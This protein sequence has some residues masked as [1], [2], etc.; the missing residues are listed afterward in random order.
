MRV[1]FVVRLV[2][3]HSF[4]VNTVGSSGVGS[5]CLFPENITKK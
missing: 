2:T 3:R 4:L 5:G 1:L